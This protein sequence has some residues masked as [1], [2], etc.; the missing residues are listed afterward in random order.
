MRLPPS[1]KGPIALGSQ[2][3]MH[4]NEL[5]DIVLLGLSMFLKLAKGM[6]ALGMFRVYGPWLS[7]I[8]CLFM[9]VLGHSSHPRKK[10][11][12]TR[13]T[14]IVEKH[15]LA[16]PAQHGSLAMPTSFIGTSPKLPAKMGLVGGAQAC[17]RLQ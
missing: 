2:G 16:V 4:E 9:G 15:T 14:F 7:N 1:E 5:L 10:N 12:A 11:L 6:V 3:P 13:L 17:L 8:Q